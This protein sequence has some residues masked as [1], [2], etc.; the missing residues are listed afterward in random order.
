MGAPAV[1]PHASSGGWTVAS[2]C[3][4]LQS[5]T[6]VQF[7]DITDA[8]ARLVRRHRLRAGLVNVQTRHTTTGIVVN[9]HEPLL[10]EDFRRTLQRVAPRLGGYAHDDFRRRGPL[11]VG[12]RVNGHAHCRALLL[13]CHATL[14]VGDGGLCLGRWQRVFFVELDGPQAREVSVGLCGVTDGAGPR[15]VGPRTSA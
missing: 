3:L 6:E 8:V 9:E 2:E 4:R 12:E 15:A 13:P 1:L 5:V 11:P 7:V 14:N 10:L